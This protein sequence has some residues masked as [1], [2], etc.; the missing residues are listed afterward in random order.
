[1]KICNKCNQELADELFRSSPGGGNKN[2]CKP[3]ES[4]AHRARRAARQGWSPE[5]S[6]TKTVPDGFHVRGISTYYDDEGKVRGQWVKSQIDEDHRIQAVLDAVA[7]LAEDFKG[8]ADP[9]PAPEEN[10]DDLLCVY[11]F[12]DPHF[13]MYAWADEA[14]ENFDLKIAERDLVTAVDHLVSLA[15][16]AKQALIISLGDMFHSDSKRSATTAGTQVDTDCRYGKVMQVVI[17][18]MKRCIDRA[19]EKHA[20]VSVICASGNHDELSSQVLAVCLSL[21]YDR[22]S[23]VKIN[24]SPSKFYWHRFG[25][26]L[27]GVHHGDTAKPQDLP[28]VMAC[29]RSKDWGET[30]HRHFYCGHVHHESV[31]EFPGVVVETFRTLA[32]KDA[33][34][35]AQG[36]R[37]GRDMRMD[38]WHV[39]DGPI[40]RHIVGIRQVR[41][42]QRGK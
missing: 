25:L 18:A 16:P 9:I 41:R 38:V 36:Y 3:C 21:F 37:S 32:P 2:S 33:W 7:T 8:V 42:L 12:G 34:H 1:M 23:R 26:N 14:G 10:T 20:E 19:L 24:T 28:G 27:I 6:M 39:E 11:P 5:H 40:N 17:R 29:D 4:V 13:G 30:V 15:P 22:E 35:A 31:K